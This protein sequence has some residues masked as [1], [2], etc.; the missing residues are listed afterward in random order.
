MKSLLEKEKWLDCTWSNKTK[1]VDMKGGASTVVYFYKS[2][3]VPLAWKQKWYWVVCSSTNLHAYK[4]YVLLHQKI[5]QVLEIY[6]LLKN[7]L[8]QARTWQYF[9]LKSYYLGI[10]ASRQDIAASSTTARRARVCVRP[11][12]NR[13]LG[14][15]SI[16][17]LLP[18]RT[19]HGSRAGTT[20]PS[21]VK[22]FGS[23]KTTK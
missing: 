10:G 11:R 15:I 22:T 16:A 14:S 13:Q 3:E 23:T 21:S 2:L 18:D 5:F 20:K 6:W 1:V 4:T 8:L 17:L 19:L 9:D 12:L 7:H